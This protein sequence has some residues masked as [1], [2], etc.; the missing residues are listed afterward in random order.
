[1]TRHPRGCCCYC[2]S[3]PAG[4]RSPPLTRKLQAPTNDAANE[5]VGRHAHEL[6]LKRL[7]VVR[8]QGGGGEGLCEGEQAE[9]VVGGHAMTK[10]LSTSNFV[11][12]P[13]PLPCVHSEVGSSGGPQS[14]EGSEGCFEARAGGSAGGP[15]EGAGSAGWYEALSLPLRYLLSPPSCSL[16]STPYLSGPSGS[17]QR[18]SGSPEGLE[19]GNGQAI[20]PPLSHPLFIANFDPPPLSPAPC[21]PPD[22]QPTFHP[23]PLTPTPCTPSPPAHS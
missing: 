13:L 1:M 9:K 11:L 5:M 12:S 7:S 17:G 3:F 18:G 6:A 22:T 4:P 23:P 8:M 10:T 20:P 19:R 21:G 16:P 2:R 14:G 15:R